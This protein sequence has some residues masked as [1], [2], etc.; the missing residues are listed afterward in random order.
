MT[1]TAPPGMPGGAFFSPQTVINNSDAAIINSRVR[2]HLA[3]LFVVSF[4]MSSGCSLS[5]VSASQ[6]TGYKTT[7]VPRLEYLSGSRVRVADVG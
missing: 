3:L 6:A 7:M 5:H 4:L 2:Q 1:T